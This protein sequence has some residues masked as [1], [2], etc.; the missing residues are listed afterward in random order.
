MKIIE[1][2]KNPNLDYKQF[3]KRTALEK[4][5]QTIIKEPTIITENGEIK[6][7][8]D[9]LD[10]DSKNVVED[11]KRIKYTVGKRAR[12]LV[13]TSRIFGFRPR[14]E[15]RGDYCTST[16]LAYDNPDIHQRVCNLALEI[17]KYYEK[18]NPKGYKD[19]SEQTDSKIKK[20]WRINGKS[21]F[22]S[23]II[24][25]NNP[26]KYHLDAGNFNKVFSLM[27]VFK[28]GIEGGYLSCPEYGIGFELKNNSILM[29]DG[30]SIM[31]GVTPITYTTPK[32]HRFSI[33]YYSLKKI[34]KCL[35]IDD[36]LA[37]I[38]NIKTKRERIR[39][40]MPKEHRDHLLKN[41]GKQ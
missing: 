13:S 28:E 29:F 5:Y 26:L 23:G 18:Y 19:H 11:L 17:E 30:Q 36:E 41:R 32:S 4:D 21:V 22:T 35:E 15:L 10:I 24:N 20:S 2:T 39:W 12:G 27:I 40:N 9:I 31:H 6:I 7:I 3:I 34:W 16:S 25:K 1:I 37:R 8:Y 38:R 14:M 33:V